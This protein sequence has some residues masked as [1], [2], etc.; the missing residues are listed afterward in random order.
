MIRWPY[1]NWLH[2][3]RRD[4]LARRHIHSGRFYWSGNPSDLAHA[5]TAPAQAAASTA[6][7]ARAAPPTASANG[8][9]AA[10]AAAPPHNIGNFLTQLRC[11][12][13]FFVE[14]IERRQTDV[15]D[16]LLTEKDFVIW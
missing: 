9:S 13:V 2:R 3:Y 6:A 1:F 15:G 16:F 7:T 14:D 11:C 5:A 10:A 12:C 8:A 4:G